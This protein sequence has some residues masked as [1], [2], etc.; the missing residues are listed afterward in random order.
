MLGAEGKCGDIMKKR[1]N[2]F[3][4]FASFISFLI[5]ANFVFIL[6]FCMEIREIKN[7]RNYEILTQSDQN[8]ILPKDTE[9]N[10]NFSSCEFDKEAQ[11]PEF[12]YD[13]DYVVGVVAA[14]SRGE[15]YEG[16]VA[17]AQ[18]ILETSKK[19]FLTP[20]EVVKM[21]NRYASPCETQ[22]EK[23]LVMD[24]C[25]D[26][27]IHGEKAFDDPIEYFY[28]TRGGFVSGWHENNLE[29]VATIGNH[30]FFKER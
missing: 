30:K 5:L 21:K 24:A 29:Y 28:S 18:C 15:P 7:C 1:K 3:I 26:V 19:T 13:F 8:L 16:Q 23:D 6:L 4:L 12:G 17:V 2:K 11:L 14:E 27:F 25:I 10:F 9:K 20:E 22:E